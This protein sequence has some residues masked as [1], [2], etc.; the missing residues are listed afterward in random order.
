MTRKF[1]G[2]GLGLVISRRLVELMGGR[3]SAESEAGRGSVFNFSLCLPVVADGA[4]IPPGAPDRLRQRRVLIVEPNATVRRLLAERMTKWGMLPVEA[5]NATLALE[6]LRG[7]DKFDVA[8][9]AL[10]LPEMDGRELATGML[11][12]PARTKLPLI[13]LSAQGQRDNRDGLFDVVLAKPVKA[14]QLFDA[15]VKIFWPSRGAMSTAPVKSTPPLPPQP[16]AVRVLFAKAKVEHQGALLDQFTQ[17]NCQVD[18]F[19]TRAELIDAVRRQV[20]EVVFLDLSAPVS[21]GQETARQIRCHLPANDQ[22]WL[23]AITDE[24]RP[25]EREACQAAGI[26]DFLSR[27]FTQVQLAAALERAKWR[28]PG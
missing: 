7:A 16:K 1:G 4:A 10:R 11:E 20:Y 8:L 28:L 18:A 27:P 21:S 26:D 14:T 6:R 17:L 3:I 22:T 12:L 24:L 25:G 2:T 13:L 23:V 15:F 19:G 5:E 9:F